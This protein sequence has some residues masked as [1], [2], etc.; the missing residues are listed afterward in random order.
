M[1]TLLDPVA[2]HHRRGIDVRVA[3][4]RAELSPSRGR[5]PNTCTGSASM[6]CAPTLPDIDDLQ[7]RDDW[8]EHA[9]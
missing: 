6:A 4:P 7:R 5:C 1:T 2:E 3:A 8:L 9:A